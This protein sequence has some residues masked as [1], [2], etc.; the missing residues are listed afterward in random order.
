VAHG[1]Y[2]TGEGAEQQMPM[3]GVLRRG[4][5]PPQP[6]RDLYVSVVS[7]P[8]GSG[9]EPQP[10][11]HSRHISGPQ[12]PSSRNNAPRS[13]YTVDSVVHMPRRISRIPCFV[14]T[15][16]VRIHCQCQKTPEVGIRRIPAYTLQYTPAFVSSMWTNMETSNLVE[17]LIILSPSYGLQTSL[18]ERGHVT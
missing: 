2:A 17:Q 10:P 5:P 12:K 11:T 16:D 1:K 8:D 15:N 13:L 6:S 3:S 14:M 9:A 18:K 7:S 4:C